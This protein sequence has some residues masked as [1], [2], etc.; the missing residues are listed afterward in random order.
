MQKEVVASLAEKYPDDTDAIKVILHDLEYDAMREMILSNGRRLDGRGLRDIRPIVI[1]VGLLPRTHGS[2]LFQRGETQSL[3][4]LTLGTKLDEQIIDGLLPE[5]SKRFML[6]YN[7]PP[8]SVGEVGRLGTTGR[9]EIGHGNL[10]ERSIRIMMPAESDFPYTVRLVSDILESNGSSSMATVCAATLALLDG[11]APLRKPVAGIAMGLV[12]EQDRVAILSDIL[13]NEDHLGDMDFKVAGTKD[14]ITACQMDI[15]IRGISLDIMRNA[16]EQAREGRMHI[17]G[18]MA[19]TIATPRVDL[20]PYAPRLTTLKIPTDMIGALIG[21]GGKNIRRIVAESGAQINIEDDGSVVIAATSKEA[22]DKA[23]DAI[24]RITEVPE[25]GKVYTS[26]V[27]KIMDFGVFVEFLP[28]KEGLVHV[29]QLDIK[30]VANPADVCKVGDVFEVKIVDKDDQGRWKLSR[31][32]VL[33]PDVPY[34]RAPAPKREGGDR[35]H[36]DRRPP[37]DGGSRGGERKQ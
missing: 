10:A 21:P 4:T 16:L 18:K 23:I 7:F 35:P 8:F 24:S 12:K 14:G 22:A 9:R 2:A 28:G 34:E 20:S 3:T 37:H 31:K 27:K 30:R 13:G 6:H 1:E 17:L 15:K 33:A 32:A 19:E 11:G 25:V 36:G 26:T 5:H 29:S